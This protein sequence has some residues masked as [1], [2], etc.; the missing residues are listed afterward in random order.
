VADVR[1]STCATA[2]S[3]LA[4]PTVTLVLGEKDEA[5]ANAGSDDE[6]TMCIKAEAL[7]LNIES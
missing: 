4:K 7:G 5:R 1:V 3:H 2:C 6:M